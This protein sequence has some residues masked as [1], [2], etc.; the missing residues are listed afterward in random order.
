LAAATFINNSKIGSEMDF[1]EL[2]SFIEVENDRLRKGYNY[3]DKEKEILA[4]AVK[5]SEEL[6]ELCDEVLAYNHL[7]RKQKLDNHDKENLPEEFAD[8]IITALI[9]ANSMNIDIE[10][11][12]E[13]K[14]EKVNKRYQE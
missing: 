13:K 9:L 5:L 8:V 1:K 2:L 4:N 3:S 12:L 6:G 10:K 14:V 7:Q 11:A